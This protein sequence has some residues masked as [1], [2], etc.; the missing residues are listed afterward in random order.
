MITN[1]ISMESKQR[2]KSDFDNLIGKMAVVKT[3]VGRNKFESIEG[4]ITNAY[5]EHFSIEESKTSFNSCH[6]YIDIITNTSEITIKDGD[7][8]ITYEFSR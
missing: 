2:I 7:N 5:P 3:N 4:V 1:M 8:N 6:Q